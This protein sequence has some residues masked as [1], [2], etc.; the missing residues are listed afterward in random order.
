MMHFSLFYFGSNA[1]Q[2]PEIDFKFVAQ[3]VISMNY[4]LGKRCHFFR[5]VSLFS[6]PGVELFETT[7]IVKAFPWS[8]ILYQTATPRQIFVFGPS[9]G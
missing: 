4:D 6:H 8:R 9:E 5:I 7:T 2:P 3:T 1:A